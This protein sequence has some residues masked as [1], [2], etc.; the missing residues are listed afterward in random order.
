MVNEKQIHS[1]DI[2]HEL[3]KLFQE[4]NP[5]FFNVYKQ[6]SGNLSNDQKR[7]LSG[8]ISGH[9]SLEKEDGGGG[10]GGDA[11]AGTVFTS[12]NSG[13]FTPTYGDNSASNRRKKI[14][15]GKKKRKKRS[16]IE[17]L[18]SWITDFSPER[19]SLSK[20]T[21]TEFATSL[22]QDVSKEYK[23]K[24]PKLRN[25]VDTKLPENETVT[26]YRP[27]ILDWKKKDED[28]AG[29]LQYEKAVDTESSEEVGRITKEQ[30][31]YRPAT[32]F[33]REQDVMC[34]TCIFFEEDD[35]E[36]HLVAGTIEEEDWCRLFSSEN[37]PKPAEDELVEGEDI[38]K[39]RDLE[40]YFSN[41]HPMQSDKLKRRI[42]REAVFPRQC[43]G[44][45]VEEWKGSVVPLELNHKDG[46]HGNNS[47]A[48]LELLCPNCHAL[49]PHYRVKKEGAKSA[50]DLHGGAPK[51]DPRRDSSLDKDLRKDEED[52]K[53][54]ETDS[55]SSKSD[56]AVLEQKEFMDKLQALTAKHVGDKTDD[57]DDRSQT[58]AAEADFGPEIRLS[59][60]F[61]EVY[62]EDET[63]REILDWGKISPDN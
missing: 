30:S 21:P 39:A 23:M 46:D 1:K 13:I 34:G 4:G 36:C 51:G 2:M 54:V 59:K 29:A 12:T 48:N 15:E 18:G 63:L 3:R 43:A 57:S 60:E 32:V 24:D 9:V 27:K 33:E 31:G 5:D 7:V 41:K 42:I 52:P 25:K 11:G 61:Y 56:T 26:N 55:D 14:Q 20:G 8:M 62:K 58:L 16:G 6:E 49:T 35:N 47:K 44:C 40:D 22:L 19:K 50:I 38:E 53:F 28:N 17:K 10:F 45:L 37:T